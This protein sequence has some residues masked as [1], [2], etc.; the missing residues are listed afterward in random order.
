MRKVMV[1]HGMG[2]IGKTQLAIH[3][4]RLHKDD[5]SAVFWLNGKDQSILT[6]SLASIAPRLP[7]GSPA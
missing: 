2:G 3:F 7:Q 5:F 6:Q 1:L 4:G